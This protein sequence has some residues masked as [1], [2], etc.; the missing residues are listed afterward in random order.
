LQDPLDVFKLETKEASLSCWLSRTWMTGEDVR[1]PKAQRISL[2]RFFIVPSD[3][4]LTW[5]CL[6]RFRILPLCRNLVGT[7]G[8]QVTRGAWE[9]IQATL[10]FLGD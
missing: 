8:F 2:L 1:Q 10:S 5:N 3:F 9:S 4:M 6:L 7:D